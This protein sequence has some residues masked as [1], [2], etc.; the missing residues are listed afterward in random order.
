[1]NLLKSTYLVLIF[2]LSSTIALS[3]KNDNASALND[4]TNVSDKFEEDFYEGLSNRLI[5]NYDKAIFYIKNC[6]KEDDTKPILFYELGNNYFELKDYDSAEDNFK[7]ALELMPNEEAI[8]EA[9]Q[10]TYFSQQKYDR[11][12][13]TLK[14]LVAINDKHKLTLAKVYLYT[15][16]FGQSLNLLNSYQASYGYDTSV[17]TLRNRIYNLSKDKGPIVIDLEKA[18]E[19]NPKDEK[20]YIKL[21]E[22]YKKSDKDEEATKVLGRFMQNTPD[23]P[24]LNYVLF[25][26]HLD[27]GNTEEATLIMKKITSSNFI[28]D[29]LKQRVLNEYRTYG[30]Q[31]PNYK[32]ELSSIKAT[33]LNDDNN[34]RFFME[35]SSFQLNE[36]STE[37]LL[38]VYE[39]NLNVDP[40]NYDLIKDTLLLQLYYGKNEKAMSLVKQAIEKYPSQ[41]LLY[42]INGTLLNKKGNHTKAISLYTDGLDYIVDDP[43]LKRAFY[44]KTAEAHAATGATEKAKKFRL[45]GEQITVN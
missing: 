8:L 42:L 41:P 13:A 18:L 32:K 4:I 45:K 7:K 12:I 44:L 5:K 40:N 30:K 26:E 37:S 14:S 25:Q 35:L 21:I 19:R 10:K 31:N 43:Q 9:L 20:A 38:Q 34:A 24:L 2:C 29:K 17:N 39:K 27:S 28:D 15:Q 1:M 23:S 33:T 22:I 16:Q 6:I 11:S 3:Q 36:G